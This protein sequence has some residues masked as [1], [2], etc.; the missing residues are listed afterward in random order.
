MFTSLRRHATNLTTYLKPS[1][2]PKPTSSPLSPFEESF[3]DLTLPSRPIVSPT[4]QRSRAFLRNR[5][6]K[7]ES[8]SASSGKDELND[9]GDCA[10][11]ESDDSVLRGRLGAVV[12]TSMLPLEVKRPSVSV[13]EA[14]DSGVGGEEGSE[15]DGASEEE[16]DEIR[17]GQTKVEKKIGFGQRRVFEDGEL[18]RGIVPFKREGSG[19]G[20]SSGGGEKSD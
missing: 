5:R 10:I 15:G 13:G 18:Q 16:K 1:K 3:E 14:E 7:L 20:K 8:E 9:L 6:K 19:D 17:K 4:K 11:V 12:D 2:Q